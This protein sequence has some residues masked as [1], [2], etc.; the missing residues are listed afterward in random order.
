MCN[1]P[2]LP[3]A[4]TVVEICEIDLFHL[5]LHLMLHCPPPERHL[6][7]RSLMSCEPACECAAQRGPPHAFVPRATRSSTRHTRLTPIGCVIIG[8]FSLRFAI[9]KKKK[10]RVSYTDEQLCDPHRASLPPSHLRRRGRDRGG[11]DTVPVP[12]GRLRD[13][14]AANLHQQSECPVCMCHP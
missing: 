7:V 9:K 6:H 12:D 4:H 8:F 10:R 11:L 13:S 5:I 3:E 14:S 1:G 2:Q